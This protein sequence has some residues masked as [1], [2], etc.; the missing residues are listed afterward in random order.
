MIHTTI[1]V[2]EPEAI[3]GAI[4]EIDPDQAIGSVG[5]ESNPVT[6]TAAPLNA[7]ALPAS[8]EGFPGG[9]DASRAEVRMVAPET[10]K[11]HPVNIEIYGNQPSTDLLASIRVHGVLQPLLVT[12]DDIIIAG[13]MRHAASLEA[14][15]PEVPVITVHPVNRNAEIDMLLTANR[16]RLKS[17]E[18]IAREVTWLMRIEQAKARGRQVTVGSKKLPAISPEV[19]G[20]ARDLVAKKVGIGSKKVDQCVK[21]I[22]KLDE[23]EKDDAE[24]KKL[25]GLLKKSVNKAANRVTALDEREK[26]PVAPAPKPEE[27]PPNVETKADVMTRLQEDI[28]DGIEEWPLEKLLR[29]EKALAGFKSQWETQIEVEAA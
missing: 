10:L 8:A 2:N 13:H 15:L 25:R 28:I 6:Y 21:V 4:E 24:A 3:D 9:N 22:E 17:N 7:V 26:L 27:P 1:P 23:L 16:Q 12:P 5:T 14:K 20:D 29:F 18:Q 19:V 11:P